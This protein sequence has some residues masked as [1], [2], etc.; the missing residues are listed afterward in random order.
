MKAWELGRRLDPRLVT[1]AV[2][3]ETL[4][5]ASRLRRRGALRRGADTA[6]AHRSALRP[7]SR[8]AIFAPLSGE[9]LPLLLASG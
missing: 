1:P 7:Y 4:V 6:L 5:R 3:V 8:E 9:I 2:I